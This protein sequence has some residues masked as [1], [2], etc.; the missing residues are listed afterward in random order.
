MKLATVRHQ[1]NARIGVVDAPAGRVLDL[2]GAGF[3]DM[4][5]LIDAGAAGLERVR[6][7]LAAHG[8][9]NNAWLKLADV[10]LLAPLPQPRQMRDGMS[11]ATHIRQSGAG[12]RK[13]AALLTNAAAPAT[14]PPADIDPVYR[15]RPIY[16]ITNRMS[17][18][19][20]DSVVR[21]PAYSRVADFE[22]EIAAIIGRTGRD[23]AAADAPAHIFGYTIYNDF[24]ARDIQMKEM[25]GRLGPAKGKSFDGG[26]VLGPWIV[27]RDELPDPGALAVRA[28]VNG[29]VRASA[30]TE[31]MLF[32]FADIIAYISQ[33][34]TLHAG[35]VI[36]SGTV[37]NCCGLEQ[38]RFLHDGDVIELEIDGIGTLR[39]RIAM[40]QGSAV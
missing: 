1:G 29:E 13:L 2:G 23:I 6:D 22:L 40:P 24:S 17:V 14:P 34:E 18:A 7:V 15:E 8:P 11:F 21:W 5:A 36:G 26:N 20:P 3:A 19:G 28:R 33:S 9:G 12:A 38:G 25:A 16:Y 31:G 35:E 37:G 32:S 30:T 39:N 27:T 4:L 10:E